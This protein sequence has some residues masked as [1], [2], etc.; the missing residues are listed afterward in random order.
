MPKILKKIGVMVAFILVMTGLITSVMS[1]FARNESQG[2][3]EVWLPT[4]AMVGL[5]IAPIG[6]TLFWAS[7]RLIDR[8]LP[9]ASY[10]VRTVLQGVIMALIMESLMAGVT[11]YQVQGFDAEFAA[12]WL[13]ALLAGLPVAAVMSVLG[14]LV[15]KPRME[16]LMTA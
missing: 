1:Y 12:V 3:F 13:R 6:F 9:N 8:V 7:G 2:F 15:I 5:L 4:W 10:A 16:A 14:T 11:T